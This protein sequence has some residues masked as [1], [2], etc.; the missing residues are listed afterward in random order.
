M[1]RE[2]SLSNVPATDVGD[3]IQSFIADGAVNIEA[4]QVGGSWVIIATFR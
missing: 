4:K 1:A 3:V 2:E